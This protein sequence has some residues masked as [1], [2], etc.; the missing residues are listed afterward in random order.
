MYPD[1][2]HGRAAEPEA[3]D[4]SSQERTCLSLLTVGVGAASLPCKEEE[5]GFLAASAGF[6]HPSLHR[7]QGEGQVFPLSRAVHLSVLRF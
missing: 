1:V 2:V 7:H 3:K 6:M 5:L 4:V